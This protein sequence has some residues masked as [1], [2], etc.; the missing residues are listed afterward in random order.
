LL[1]EF[2]NVIEIC[3]YSNF[4]IGRIDRTY[5][6]I[7]LPFLNRV[8]GVKDALVAAIKKAGKI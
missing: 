7:G 1:S 6:F 5:R 8:K 2:Q 4:A 3:D